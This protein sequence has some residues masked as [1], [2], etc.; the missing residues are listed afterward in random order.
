MAFLPG[1]RMI[2]GDIGKRNTIVPPPN[3]PQSLQG[4]DKKILKALAEKAIRFNCLNYYSSTK[5]SLT[6]YLLLNKLFININYVDSFRLKLMFL[7]YQNS[8]SLNAN[9]YKS[10]VAYLDLIIEGICSAGYET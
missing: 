3:V 9:D 5:E 10:Y 8:I 2:A 4:L 1:F 6:Y 7:L